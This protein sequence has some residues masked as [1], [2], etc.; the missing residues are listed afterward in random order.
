MV[1]GKPPFSGENPVSIAYKQVH[2]LPQPLNQ[3]V[4]DV[5]RPFEAIVAKLLAKDPNMRYPNAEALREDL[6]RYRT[7]EPV[8][9]LASVAGRPRPPL[10][11]CLAPAT[12]ARLRT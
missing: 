1:A 10:Q 2:D 6:R 4:A 5:P 11:R 7:G 3:L 9:A 8:M 12:P